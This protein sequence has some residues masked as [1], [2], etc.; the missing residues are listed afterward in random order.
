ME[1]SKLARRV[2]AS[3]SVH[4]SL[5]GLC[6]VIQVCAVFSPRVRNCLEYMLKRIGMKMVSVLAEWE[7]IDKP[8]QATVL[9]AGME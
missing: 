7:T 1:L 5:I 2:E 6:S 4:T 3:R 9:N 8:R